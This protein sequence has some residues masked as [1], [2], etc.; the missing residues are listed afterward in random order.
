MLAAKLAPKYRYEN[1]AVVCLNDGGVMV[2]A[3]IAM[4]LHTV[5]TMLQTAEIDLPMEP[6]A[7]GGLTESGGFSYNP[8]YQ[9]GELDELTS[10]FFQYIEA[11]KLSKLSKMHYLVHE[12]P[13]IDEHLLRGRNI[14]VVSDG[15]KTSF[16]LDIA[17]QYLKPISYEKLIVAVPLASVEA[18]DRMHIIAD[19]LYCLSVIPDY[20]DTDHYYEQHDV[21][22]HDKVIEVIEKIVYNWK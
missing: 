5:L 14:I 9:K 20:L 6:E 16:Q 17:L 12:G 21:P 18:V 2:G 10:E 7:I 13:I 1:C 19:E 22:S 3:Q 15:L 8:A 4:Q 11:E